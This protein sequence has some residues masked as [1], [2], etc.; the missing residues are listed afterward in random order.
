M[1][2]AIQAATP[3]SGE[4]DADSGWYPPLAD[5][6]DTPSDRLAVRQGPARYPARRQQT[7]AYAS[8]VNSFN[9][10]NFY[11]RLGGG[12]FLEA[13]RQSMRPE[14]DYVLIDSRTG[15]SDTSGHLH[16]PDAGSARRLLHAQQQSIEG[17]AA[18]AR[19]LVAARTQCRPPR[20][21]CSRCP[22][23]S[24][25]PRR[26]GSTPPGPRRDGAST[27]SFTTYRSAAHR[28]LGRIE[29]PIRP[30]YAYE[31]VLA[32]FG[33]SPPEFGTLLHSM[34]QI[35]ARLTGA[36]RCPGRCRRRTSVSGCWRSTGWGA[37]KPAEK[38]DIAVASPVP[39]PVDYQ[40]KSDSAPAAPRQD[41]LVYVSYARAN[42]DKSLNRFISE[43]GAEID[44]RLGRDSGVFYDRNHI[45]IGEDWNHALVEALETSQVGILLMSPHYLNSRYA[46]QK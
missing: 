19:S 37:P 14:Y 8:R 1:D 18:V 11:E 12:D 21:G 33:G 24:R 26:N 15:V 4:A 9:W 32:T 5:S 7:P 45:S 25:T 6:C 34:Q 10:D 3:A 23:E 44:S 31:E 36:T 41:Y 27:S 28:L 35:A 39:E 29:I 13:L 20:P 42:A 38:P 43:L 30:Y 16:R 46:G 2:F 17:A 22:R 40:S